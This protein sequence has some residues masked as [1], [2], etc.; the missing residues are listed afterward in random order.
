MYSGVDVNNIQCTAAL[1]SMV[2]P[3]EFW[4]SKVYAT[5]FCT[6]FEGGNMGEEGC[7]SVPIYVEVLIR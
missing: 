7:T 1:T 4:A 6:N 3:A 5:H 2:D